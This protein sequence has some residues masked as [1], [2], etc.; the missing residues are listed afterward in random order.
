MYEYHADA[1]TEL[2]LLD[3]AVGMTKGTMLGISVGTEE[4]ILLG[5]LLGVTRNVEEGVI[6]GFFDGTRV[7]T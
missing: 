6:G 7:G 2:D 5:L 4:G 3:K 1:A